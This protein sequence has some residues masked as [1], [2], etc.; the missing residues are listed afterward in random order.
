VL[1][2]RANFGLDA[3]KLF[4]LKRRDQ[5]DRDPFLS[6]TPGTADTVDVGL[7]VEWNVVVEDMADII[8]V[9]TAG[10]NVSSYE[11]VDSIVFKAFDD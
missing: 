1:H 2:R 11:D 4:E 10:G 8:D 6:G 5:S 7:R 3:L 9:D